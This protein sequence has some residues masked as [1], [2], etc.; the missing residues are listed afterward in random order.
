MRFN[1]FLGKTACEGTRFFGARRAPAPDDDFDILASCL[2]QRPPPC[3]VLMIWLDLN[4]ALAASN[5][6]RDIL[7]SF[8]AA[9]IFVART[10]PQPASPAE[11]QRQLLAAELCVTS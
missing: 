6:P 1:G 7:A 10:G 2:R 8:A 3:L 5:V 9:K 11:C 4:S